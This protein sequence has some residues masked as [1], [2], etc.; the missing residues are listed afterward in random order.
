MR[1]DYNLF[2]GTTVTGA[3]AGVWVRGT[4][5]VDGERFTGR[6][7]AGQFLRRAAFTS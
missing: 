6:A 7:G 3:P 5:V 4:Q 2:E 1:V